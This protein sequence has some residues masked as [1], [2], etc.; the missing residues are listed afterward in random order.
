MVV[1]ANTMATLDMI[2]GVDVTFSIMPTLI[3]EYLVGEGEPNGK[4]KIRARSPLE[5]SR[6]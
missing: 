3:P 1:E 2:G 6:V 4:E 5:K